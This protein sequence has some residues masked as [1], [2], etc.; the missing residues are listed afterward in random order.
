MLKVEK[1]IEALK[2]VKKRKIGLM[3]KESKEVTPLLTATDFSAVM[4][5]RRK[6]R[7]KCV[8]VF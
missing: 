3:D 7:S 5:K 8:N 6:K 1:E 4:F 2:G